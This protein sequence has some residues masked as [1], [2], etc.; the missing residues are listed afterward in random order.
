M[1]THEHRAL[2]L[3]RDG[4]II[5]D[6]GYPHRLE[7]LRFKEELIPYL[8]WAAGQGFKLI[9]VSNQAG[10]ARGLFSM[11]QYQVFQKEVEKG[12]RDRGVVLD[13]VYFCP[14]HPQGTVP[15]YNT[16]SVNRK[17]KPGLFLEAQRVFNLDL[18][19]SF[20]LGDK[21]SDRI[22]L[23]GLRCLILRSR[24]TEHAPEGTFK[25]IDAIFEEISHE[26]HGNNKL[27]D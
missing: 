1:N 5:E 17:P 23:P 3:D 16:D 18:S 13:G 25:D 27:P 8:K 2:F 9:S 21:F 20:M 26:I 22:E 7:D 6:V 11:E 14:C 12:L 19:R 15:P 10:I 24:Y 4:V